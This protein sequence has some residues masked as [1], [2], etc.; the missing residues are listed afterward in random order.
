MK[1][2]ALEQSSLK[3]NA[4]ASIHAGAPFFSVD[5]VIKDDK[6]RFIK[7]KCLNVEGTISVFE[8]ETYGM[9]KALS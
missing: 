9:K 4:D 5:M 7:A 8:A 2:Y 6:S 3:L 1:W